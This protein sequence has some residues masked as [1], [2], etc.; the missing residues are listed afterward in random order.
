[1]IL[2]H[3]EKYIDR[4]LTGKLTDDEIRRIG[5]PWSLDLV[6]RSLSSTGGTIQAAMAAMQNKRIG[7][8][9]SGGT[10]HAFYD[11]GSGY[12][13]I[14]DIAVAARVLLHVG[15]VESKPGSIVVIDLDVHQGDGTAS[16]FAED[17]RVVTVSAHSK[18]NFPFR[19]QRSD[20]DIDLEDKT[21][22]EQYMKSIEQAITNIVDKHKPSL[23]FYQ[24]GV[25]P[26]A[27][28]SQ[29]FINQ[30]HGCRYLFTLNLV[31]R[32]AREAIIDKRG[33][34]SP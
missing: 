8:N 9:L 3:S 16:I 30:K 18:N 24:A 1:V 10:H 6:F 28:G 20:Y 29:Y 13:C 31:H 17:D 2:A 34:A 25:D 33:H 19:K 11:S 32:H 26:L 4:F 5:F 27:E 23:I 21:T 7:C 15:M 22:D 12:C 14:N